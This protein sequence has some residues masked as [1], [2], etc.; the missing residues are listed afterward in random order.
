MMPRTDDLILFAQVIELGSFSK[1]AE[2][3]SLANSVV[4]KRIARLEEELGSTLIHRTTRRLTLTE[5]G[6]V[7]YQRARLVAQSAQEA[8]DA[9]TGYSQALQGHIRMSVPTISGELLLAEAVAE[10]CELHPAISVDMSLEN[11]FVDLIGEGYDLVIRT[12]HLDDSSLIARHILDS[13]WTICAAPAY[14]SRHGKPQAPEDLLQHNCLIYSYQESGARDWLFS[15]QGE[16]Y[17]LRVSGHFSTDNA[18]A[19]RK[20]AIAGFGLAYVPR[21]LVYP[22]LQAGRL[23]ELLP[24]QVGKV[25]GIYAVYP[26]SRQPPRKIKLLIEH[27]R[28]RYMDIKHYF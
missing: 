9:V 16:I 27:I 10:F 11:R 12:G 26:Y 14:I 23:V 2:A 3:N 25:L 19:L 15:R 13:R 8:F 6:Q 28:A 1:A 5:A 22:D 24:R 7:L 17:P 20:A 21:C 18:A 4:S